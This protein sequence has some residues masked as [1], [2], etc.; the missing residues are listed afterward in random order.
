M[1]V[2]ENSNE[3][4]NVLFIILIAIA[5]FAA[6]SA[7]V[8]NMMRGSGGSV[9]VS[10]EKARIYAD[11]I[12]DYARGIRQAVQE[13]RIS[14]GCSET[15]ISFE[16]NE[17]SGYINGA[18][19]E[20]QV[21][22]PDGGGLRYIAV[23]EGVNDGSDWVFTGQN[24]ADDIGS[25]SAELII[26]LPNISSSICSAVNDKTGITALGNDAAIDFTK[27]T[28][29]YNATQTIDFSDNIMSGCLSYDNS[30]TDEP[31]FYQVLIAQ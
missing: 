8:A 20:C 16:N 6:L 13:L 28:G 25:S 27:F 30:G 24:H 12:I 29:A 10:E 26:I 17:V 11:E 14:N 1:S 22:H 5:L 21:F 3:R 15:E 9:E 7:V 4:G 2:K 23:Q 19:T 31:F 18:N